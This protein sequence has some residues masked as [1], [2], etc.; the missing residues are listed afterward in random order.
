[1]DRTS[2]GQAR[3]TGATGERSERIACGRMPCSFRPLIGAAPPVIY[4]SNKL[5]QDDTV[6]NGKSQMD[7]NRLNARHPVALVWGTMWT[8]QSGVRGCG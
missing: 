2:F 6:W 5:G 4:K 8:C 7:T 3:A 1:M